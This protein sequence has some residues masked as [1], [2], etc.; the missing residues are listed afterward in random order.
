MLSL[1]EILVELG[2]KIDLTREQLQEK[3]DQKHKELSGLVSL[4]GAGHLIARD[5]G[6]NLLT[7]ERKPLKIEKLS[8]GLKNIKVNGRITQISPM[9]EF[10]RKDG[11]KGR[12][13]NIFIS[14][15]TGQIRVPL[16][17]KQADMIGNGTLSEGFV[18][19]VS[20]GDV[21]KNIYGGLEVRLPKYS[22]IRKVEDDKSIPEAQAKISSQRIDIRNA[23]E[24]FYEIHGNFVQLFNTNPIFRLCPT[25]R[26]G[27][28]K[29][30]KG[31][32]CK[33]H[34]KVEPIN[35]M[36]ISGIVDDGTSSIRAV[37]FRD[38]A[39]EFSGIE[40][41]VLMSMSQ[42]EGLNLIK[43]SVLG[44]EVVLSGKIRKNKLFDN[45]E[46]VVDDV[47]NL[48][49]ESESKRLIREIE[50]YGG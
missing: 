29:T 8:D 47:K 34:G 18:I 2:N 4:E 19:E 28:E 31:Y 24:G 38:Q 16:W 11:T 39:Q 36:I 48:D 32:V 44:K 25:C 46:F 14:D 6:V 26:T 40:P 23:A 37:F 1:E 9:R 35:T 30:D 5:L 10:D 45:L 15:G 12:V 17:D 3:I 50:K 41:S 49:I 27:L 33:E 13:C 42:D 43:E 22:Q 7:I 21:K 20:G